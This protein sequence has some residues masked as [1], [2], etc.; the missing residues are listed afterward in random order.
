[1][2][3]KG[4]PN[5][6]FYCFKNPRDKKTWSGTTYYLGHSLQQYVGDVDYLGPVKV[7]WMMNQAMKGIAKLTKLIFKKVWAPNFSLVKNIYGATYLKKKMKKK[8]YDFLFAPAAASELAYL[9]T[10]VPIV[11]FGDATFKIYTQSYVEFKS[12]NTF[13]RW[14]GN[15]LEKRALKKSDVVIFSSHWAAQSAIEDYGVPANKVEVLQMGAN[16]DSVPDPAIIFKKEEDPELKLLFLS[17]EW[18]R[19]GGSIAFETL[20]H[21][22]SMGVQARLIVCG[23]NPPPE[24][25]HSCMEVVPFINKNEAKNSELFARLLAS[26]HFLILPTRA[27]CTPMVN[28]EANA[29]GIPAITTNVGGVA[30]VV[31]DGVNGYCLPLSANG[32]DYASLIATIFLDKDRYHQLIVSSRARFDELLNWEHFAQQLKVVLERHQLSA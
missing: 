27:D 31:K 11:Y 10:A 6:A 9:N 22:H 2:E 17:V 19:K 24:F 25:V 28:A 20:K 18:E 21:L 15:H 32:L 14:E 7:P 4:R 8:H 3:N 5:I 26:V 29:F 12:L 23:V 1:M 30:D 13:S 16:M